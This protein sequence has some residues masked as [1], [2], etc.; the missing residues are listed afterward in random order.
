MAV[1][2]TVISAR[3]TEQQ[4][5]RENHP[6]AVFRAQRPLGM[7]RYLKQEK[8]DGHYRRLFPVRA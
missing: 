6:F 7:E 2:E 5:R 4:Q 8:A 1:R 3:A